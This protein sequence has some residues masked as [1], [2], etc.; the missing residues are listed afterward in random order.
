MAF[1][2]VL[3]FELHEQ[4]GPN[5]V[6]PVE[7]MSTALDFLLLS[8]C[9]AH[10]ILAPYT[11]VEESFN[12]HATHDVLAYGVFPRGLKHVCLPVVP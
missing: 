2:M 9:W 12:L 4:L 3:M 5:T 10:V 1:S 8:T 11:K 6:R 7:T